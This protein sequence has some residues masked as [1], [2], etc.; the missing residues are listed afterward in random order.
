MR[1]LYRYVRRFRFAL[2]GIW[3]ALRRDFS[4]RW[5][6]ILLG[7]AVGLTAYFAWPLSTTQALLLVLAYI[8]VLLTELQNSALEEA[9]DHLHPTQHD[10]IGRTKDMAAGSVLLAGVFALAV[11]LAVLFF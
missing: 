10:R 1:G 2:G 8:L 9:L 4:F 5:Q 3:Y 11:I 6:V 7:L